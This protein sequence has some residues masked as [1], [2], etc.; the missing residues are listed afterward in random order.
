MN[1]KEWKIQRKKDLE[2]GEI[3]EKCLQN[4]LN[5]E[6]IITIESFRNIFE[7]WN[8]T[9]RIEVIK[10]IIWTSPNAQGFA[11]KVSELVSSDNFQGEID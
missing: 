1:K 4:H 11:K 9:Q 7:D 8:D 5:T 3:Q 10:S 2:R 6:L